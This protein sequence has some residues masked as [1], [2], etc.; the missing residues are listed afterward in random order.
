[1]HRNKG[2]DCKLCRS[3]PPA[4]RHHF[5]KPASLQLC[6]PVQVQIC[7][8]GYLLYVTPKVLLPVR[9]ESL[10][11]SMVLKHW[12]WSNICQHKAY[13][14][15]RALKFHYHLICLIG[16]KKC[17]TRNVSVVRLKVEG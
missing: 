17:W 2:F 7:Q 6:I 8:H 11:E 13:T 4:R 12:T 15:P 3:L 5:V 9:Y 16:S 14:T 10:S 1:M